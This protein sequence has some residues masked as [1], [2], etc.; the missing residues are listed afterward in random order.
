MTKPQDLTCRN[1]RKSKS[2]YKKKKVY[3]IEEDNK[4]RSSGKMYRELKISRRPI[5]SH[6]YNM[7]DVD[8][9]TK[10]GDTNNILKYKLPAP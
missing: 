8:R 1:F 10:V 6:F 2:N 4:D 5:I 3:S 7:K 9:S